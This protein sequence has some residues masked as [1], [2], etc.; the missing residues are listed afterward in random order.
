M[1]AGSRHRG[2]RLKTAS[3]EARR[4]QG[5]RPQAAGAPVRPGGAASGFW[6]VG[7]RRAARLAGGSMTLGFGR[8]EILSAQANGVTLLIAAG[9]ISYEAIRRLLD[10]PHVRAGLIL[11]VA[12]AGV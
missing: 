2:L 11:A 9:F 5:E 8:A 12:L 10:P 4:A 7:R 1:L 6:V 3:G